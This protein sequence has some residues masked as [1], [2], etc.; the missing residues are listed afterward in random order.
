MALGLGSGLRA[1]RRPQRSTRDV[2][3]DDRVQLLAHLEIAPEPSG[4]GG[5]A[6][7]ATPRTDA[8][9]ID[10]TTAL[11]VPHL[12][13]TADFAR[14]LER[15]N[16]ELKQA[17]ADVDI[18]YEYKRTDGW[19]EWAVVHTLIRSGEVIVVMDRAAIDAARAKEGQP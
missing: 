18:L 7:S 15:E 5:Q 12:I 17:F 2:L 8:V 16:A 11:V 14:E 13:V 6:M 19:R 10:A 3:G 9:E 4:E 1:P